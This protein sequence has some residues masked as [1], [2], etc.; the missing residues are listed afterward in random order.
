MTRQ[1]ISRTPWLLWLSWLPW[2]KVKFW[3]AQKDRLYRFPDIQAQLHSYRVLISIAPFDHPTM[4]GHRTNSEWLKRF[5]LTLIL[6]SL[7]KLI[8]VFKFWLRLDNINRYYT[9]RPMCISVHKVTAWGIFRAPRLPRLLFLFWIK[10]KGQILVTI[11]E[12]LRYANIS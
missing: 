11:S 12:L 6:E 1:K 2:S 10:V 3:W 8:I 5:S 4:C 9:L 7:L